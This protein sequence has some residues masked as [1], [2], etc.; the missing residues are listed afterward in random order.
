MKT[1]SLAGTVLPRGEVSCGRQ[2]V[3]VKSALGEGITLGDGGQ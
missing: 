1:R 3:S 2:R